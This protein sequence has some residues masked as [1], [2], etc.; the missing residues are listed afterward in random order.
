MY[1]DIT[2]KTVVL[3]IMLLPLVGCS[4]AMNQAPKDKPISVSSAHWLNDE[5]SAA[6]TLAQGQTAFLALDD[7]FM[8]IAS[9][10]HL[11]RNAKHN[12]DLQYYILKDDFIGH[13]MLQELLKAADRGVKVRLLIDDQNGTQ[14]DD[15]LK[16]L[17]SHPNFSI[18]I[19]NPY[20]YRNFR[21]IDYAFRLK[22]INHRMHNKLIIADGA[23]AVTGG[24]NI[25]REYFDA[26]ESF[27][28]TDLDILFYGTAV[29]EA[30]AVFLQFWNDDLSYSVT[31]LL[32]SSSTAELAQLQQHYE[33]DAVRKNNVENRIEYA[34]KVLSAELKQN[35][36]AGQMRTLSQ[37]ILIKFVEQRMIN[38]SFTNKCDI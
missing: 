16:A 30:N 7:A 1:K 13:M 35:K 12:I 37:T 17:A 2:L 34:Q 23:I 21:V 27:Q 31:Q 3:P 22:Q 29:Q 25:S 26:S 19:F 28:F 6:E 4:L 32:G 14:L 9:R 36:F 38:S 18:K 24:R 33:L 8:S 10:I 11:I 5:N 15:T 20:K